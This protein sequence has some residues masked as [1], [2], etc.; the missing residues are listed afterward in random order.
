MA[1]LRAT[2]RMLRCCRSS[3][4]TSRTVSYSASLTR[5]YDALFRGSTTRGP[6]G[7]ARLFRGRPPAGSHR[8]AGRRL[9]CRCPKV[10]ASVFLNSERERWKQPGFRQDLPRRG[11]THQP[12][13]RRREPCARRR[14]PGTPIHRV[15]QALQGRNNRCGGLCRPFRA[16]RALVSRTQGGAALCPGLICFG[17]FGAAAPCSAIPG[18]RSRTEATEG[19]DPGNQ[20]A[21]PAESSARWASR[22]LQTND[23]DQS[24]ATRRPPTPL[25]ATAARLHPMGRRFLDLSVA[26]RVCGNRFQRLL[27]LDFKPFGSPSASFGVPSQRIRVLLLGSLGH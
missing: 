19:D 8:P 25:D 24:A 21:L 15:A 26:L 9:S 10:A 27:K 20:A 14:R 12:G 6:P 11:R 23:A 16:W 18:M 7:S 1:F 2:L 22:V 4:R 13:A 17:P 3:S 5:T